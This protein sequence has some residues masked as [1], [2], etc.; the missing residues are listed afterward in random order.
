MGSSGSGKSTLMS[1]L[2]CLDRPTARPLSVRRRRCRAASGTGTR[3]HPQRAHRL[4]V[5]ELQPAGAHQ[6]ARERRRCRCSIRATHRRAL[7]SAARARARRRSSCSGSAIAR[8][9]TPGAALRRPAAA[10]RDRARADQFA[11]PAAGRRADRQSRHPHLARDHGDAGALNREQG[12]T[13]VVVTH[14]PD[15]AAYADRVITM[16]DGG[17]V[18]DERRDSS[19]AARTPD[20]DRDIAPR[21][22]WRGARCRPVPRADSRH[23][24]RRS[25]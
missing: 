12:V 25:R 3:A 9:N 24:L 8:G 14:E 19:A 7:R 6:R 23:R 18:S 10:R 17:I 4:R 11:E 13:I 5:P 1:I 22:Q 21:A 15:I 20:A 2:G 16:R